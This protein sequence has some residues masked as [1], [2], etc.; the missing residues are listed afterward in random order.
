MF[1]TRQMDGIFAIV[2]NI[3]LIV[4]QAN[5]LRCYPL[6]GGIPAGQHPDGLKIRSDK[7]Q[8]EKD[9]L[10]VQLCAATAHSNHNLFFLV[11]KANLD[12]STSLA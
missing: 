7:G 10:S 2:G 8:P 4:V 1:K 6:S 5:L 11:V 3:E 12:K 9:W